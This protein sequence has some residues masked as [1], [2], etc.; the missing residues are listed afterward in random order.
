[1]IDRL[2]DD[3]ELMRRH[4]TGTQHDDIATGAVVSRLSRWPP[5]ELLC[6]ITKEIM[7]DPVI[8]AGA[9]KV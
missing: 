3:A 2:R 9:Q 4:M 6:P 8:A 7:R 1:M 5:D